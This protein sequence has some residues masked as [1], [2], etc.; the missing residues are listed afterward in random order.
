[1][2]SAKTAI[3]GKAKAVSNTVWISFVGQVHL[4]Q[5]RNSPQREDIS[6]K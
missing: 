2:V 5:E 3:L 1:L 4:P 6:E